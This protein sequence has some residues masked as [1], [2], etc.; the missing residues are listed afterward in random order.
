LPSRSGSTDSANTLRRGRSWTARVQD[1]P[2]FSRYTIA[3][4]AAATGLLLRLALDPVWHGQLPY[5]TLFPAVVVSAWLGGLGP[6]LLTTFLAALGAT[7]F[8]VPP[9]HTLRITD[10][11]EGLGLAVFV[12]VGAVVSALN[13]TWRRG[14]VALADSEERLAVT[15]ASI[16]DAVLT[17]DENGSVLTMNDVAERLT[18]WPMH[19]AIGRPVEEVLILVSEAPASAARNPVREVLRDGRVTTLDGHTLLVGRDGR[20]I[21]IDDS[22]A[23]IRSADRTAGVVLVFRDVS[24]RRRLADERESQDRIARELAAIVETSDDAIVSKDL[25]GTIRSWNRGAERI[26]GYTADEMIGRSIRTIIPEERWS[27]EEDVLRQLRQGIRVDHFETIRCRKDGSEVPVSLTISPILSAAG[28]VVGAS[29]IA[30][31]ITERR[32]A[33]AER[34]QLLEREQYA[35]A[36]IERAGRL[37]D[38]FLAVLSHELRTPLNAVMGYTQLLIS[39]GLKADDVTHAYQAIQR[40]AQAQARLVESLL[41]LSRVLAGKLELNSEVVD[42][43]SVVALAV[44]ALRPEALKKHISLEFRDES[45]IRVFGD[46]SRLQQV[47]WNLLSNAIKFTPGGGRVAVHVAADDRDAH[48]R[49]ED[50][51]RGIPASLLPFIFDRFRQGEGERGHSQA[52]LG[53][54]LALVRELVH[55]H[56]GTVNARSAGEGHGSTFVVRLPLFLSRQAAAASE[57]V[58]SLADQETDLTELQ[59]DVL[60]V[61]DERD[62]RDMVALMLETR[63]ATVRRVGSAVEAFDALVE[64]P[65]DVLLADLGMALEDGYSLIRRWRLKEQ[66]ARLLRVPAIAVTAYASSADRERALTAGYDWH[67]AK[68]VDA[69][70]LIKVI[71]SVV[72]T[73][74]PED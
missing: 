37:K 24:E 60:V 5:V 31:D 66:E 45:G 27:E 53:L 16:G 32:Q 29:K 10:P 34:A 58:P 36:E 14:T 7:Y 30:R 1:L 25:H 54:G 20:R 28:V 43:P 39:G 3:V 69:T 48:V 71:A 40:N 6:G 15:L 33:E 2:T 12:V 65:P 35:R 52:G 59:L 26:F 67:V 19:E 64:R 46:S 8:W 55:A 23:P 51:G 70:E 57:V 73:I 21:P 74:K 11:G 13:E 17:T 22:A 61:D 63:G 42:L 68:P 62:A 44:D 56:R 47:F 49:I 41:D 72:T 18:G 9:L 38:D 4:V 50:N